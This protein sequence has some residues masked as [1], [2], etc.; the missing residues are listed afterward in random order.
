MAIK[1]TIRTS[2]PFQR[3]PHNNKGKPPLGSPKRRKANERRTRNTIHRNFPPTSPQSWRSQRMSLSMSRI[4]RSRSR[5]RMLRHRGAP[6]V[7][8]A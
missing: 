1:K 6:L 2:Q 4:D 3:T 8:S 7:M 5:R